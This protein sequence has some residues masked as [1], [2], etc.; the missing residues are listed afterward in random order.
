MNGLTTEELKIVISAQNDDL[1]KKLKQNK[2]S[3][4]GFGDQSKQTAD[5]V[6]SAFDKIKTGAA[7]LFSVNA[8]KGF[9]AESRSAWNV[10]LEAEARLARVMRNTMNATEDQIEA[11][12]EWAAELQ[13]IGVI[14]DEVTLSGLQ[15]LATY[16]GDAESLKAMAV[17]LDDMLAQQ[18]GLNATAESSVTIA[19]ML[20]K[21]LDGQTS[22]LSRYGYSFT[23]A[24]EQ[25]LKYGTE[26]QRVAA[27]A[28]VVEQSV[29]GMNAA[30]AQTDAGRLKQFDNEIG[31]IKEQFGEAF[32]EIG[33]AALP[34]FK[35]L[36]E[37]ASAV[38]PFISYLADGV[39][40][41]CVWWDNLNPIS[42]KFLKIALVAAVA[43]PAVTAAIKLFTL[44][45]T[46]MYAV[47]AL[48]I[49]QTAT[50]G[51]VTKAAFGW[52]ALAA[53]AIAL[54]ASFA[55]SESYDLGDLSSGAE[56]SS[57]SLDGLSG[58]FDTAQKTAEDA[59]GGFGKLGDEMD[60]LKSSTSALAGFDE[61][62]I[63]DSDSG[64]IVSKLIS[65]DDIS[66]I[67]GLADALAGTD[68]LI[69]ETQSLADK[70]VHVKSSFSPE[71]VRKLEEA[72]G[73]VERIFGKG[74][75]GFWK[76]VGEDMFEGIENGNWLPLLTDANGVVESI[77]G[78]K[79]TSFWEDVGGD[80][81][82]AIEEGNWLPI[83]T[84]A[85]G[86]VE[87]VFG[88]PWT[89]FWG[90]V[91]EDMYEGI[92]NKNWLPLLTDANGVVESIFGEKWTGFWEDVGGDMYEGIEN[93]N[94]LPLLEDLEGG[95]RKLFGDGWTGFWEDVGG[96]MIE[97]LVGAI[98]YISDH[99]DE[100]C[101]EIVEKTAQI[102]SVINPLAEKEESGIPTFRDLMGYFP[103]M[104][105]SLNLPKNTETAPRI[106]SAY[107]AWDYYARENRT[108][109]DS[110]YDAEDFYAKKKRL[111][112]YAEGGFPDYG[113]LFIAN[114]QGPELVGRLGGRT[115][116]ANNDQITSGIARAVDEVMSRYFD[117]SFYTPS[118]DTYVFV[119][120]DQIAARTER[121]RSQH[122]K[123]TGGK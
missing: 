59:A 67:D 15:E 89:D 113:E 107:D 9:A 86:I 32:T 43:V 16:L 55:D 33:T 19:T 24:Q 47:Q 82:D 7:A 97:G 77:F 37:G 64:S 112:G 30:L 80:M 74:W 69:K 1:L 98:D 31:D 119:D 117:S 4:A 110:V 122:T 44:A 27:L 71:M 45:Q 116:V 101:V 96:D 75:T 105:D 95:V 41:L 120:G 85:N 8:I 62:N 94:W 38:A 78:E 104:L 108:Q 57:L 106:N 22:A 56:L 91:G 118:G 63:I 99:F 93:K 51:S 20:G 23:E 18:Y 72:N 34:V 102:L 29:G 84:E 60:E 111:L 61:F 49:P 28:E 48:L 83:L 40:G 21:V 123:M 52:L 17:V 103:E 76:R 6:M 81:F 88:S 70:G 92:Q 79:W 35:I 3:L 66:M 115:V 39:E 36:A 121:R 87:S 58:S 2:E 25:L 65:P 12:K 90:R 46:G 73:V 100:L 10:Q 54:I 26:Q 13:R 14:G 109:I 68:D 114:E 11:T 5:T 53:G 42:Q 50:L